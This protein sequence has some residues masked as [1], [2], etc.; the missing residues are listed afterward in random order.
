MCSPRGSSGAKPVFSNLYT[1][2][3]IGSIGSRHY[4][5]AREACGVEV[6]GPRTVWC[7]DSV[8][9]VARRSRDRLPWPSDLSHGLSVLFAMTRPSR[10]SARGARPVKKIIVDGVSYEV[11]REVF[12]SQSLAGA[13]ARTVLGQWAMP[14]RE[15]GEDISLCRAE[16]ITFHRRSCPMFRLLP[17]CRLLEDA[18]LRALH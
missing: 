18:S 11:G 13:L 12:R 15:S 1:G 2:S 17:A 7:E 16:S 4:S 5:C 3:S 6:E 9:F 14:L 10:Q 8:V